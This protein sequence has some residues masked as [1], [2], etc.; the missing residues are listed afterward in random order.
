MFK[1]LYLLMLKY[2]VRVKFQKSSTV[3]SKFKKKGK[4]ERKIFNIEKRY[5]KIT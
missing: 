2:Y 1:M 4:R 3:Y 5:G